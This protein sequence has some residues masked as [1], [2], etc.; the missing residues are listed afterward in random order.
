MSNTLR[1]IEKII[2]PPPPHMVGDGFRV[3]SIF[4]NNEI[5]KYRM[6]PFFL[7]DYNAL[8]EFSPAEKP[9]GVGVHPHRGFETVTIA[10]KGTIAHHDSAGNSG[11]I[12]DGEVQWMT[13]GSGLLHKEYHE[14][15]FS[16][17]GG[18]F[19]MVQLWVNLP[20]RHKMTKPKYQELTAANIGV[21]ELP[22]GAGQI[23]V[24]AGSFDTVKGPAHTFTPMHVYNVHLKN[25]KSVELPLELA[26]NTGILV[27][28]GNVLVNDKDL[29]VTDQFVLFKNDGDCIRL[30][31]QQDAII[32]VLSGE[33][34]DEPIAQYGPFLMNT[35]QEVEEAINDVSAGKFGV[36]E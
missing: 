32:L 24:L 10:Y 19:H 13:A 16:R 1:S 27:V 22:S 2:V 11:I 4:P 14:E 18:P 8:V 23:H 9:R 34:I 28:Q 36:L 17:Q 5:R 29:A 33:P 3:H 12:R 6:S 21:Y 7:M 31:A 30:K 25:E 15:N 35:W 26:Y 20:A